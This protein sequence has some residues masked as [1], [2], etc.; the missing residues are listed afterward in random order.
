MFR[1]F[2]RARPDPPA[3]RD[4]AWWS[5]AAAAADAP[6]HAAIAGLRER[7]PP[8]EAGA[9]GIDERER[10]EEM[11]EGLDALL[12]LVEAGP[13]PVI[14]TQHRVIGADACHFF[15]PVSCADQADAPGKIFVTARRLVFAGGSVRAWSWHT[16]RALVRSER[17][18]LVEANSG[19]RPAAFRCNTY[20]DALV[21]Q[22]L[23]T[24][25]MAASRPS[26]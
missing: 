7:I 8:D 24:R 6:S 11:I 4:R 21:A 5:E 10:R 1:L 14:E 19:A 2:R 3:G 9:D 17:D 16:V 22:Y 25:L 23:G 20:G 12:T 13:M 15:A 26:R 18:L